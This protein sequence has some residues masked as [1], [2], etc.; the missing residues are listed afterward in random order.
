V[1]WHSHD[2]LTWSSVDLDLPP[3]NH[4]SQ[5][6]EPVATAE[7]F[8]IISRSIGHAWLS[9]NG[10][11]WRLIRTQRVDLNDDSVFH[12]Y[13]GLAVASDD[14]IVALGSK[15]DGPEAGFIDVWVGRFSEML[16]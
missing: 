8:V 7:G 4:G 15:Q 3:G 11:D 12:D 16:R 9:T 13:I 14:L 2:G 10:T 1:A 6:G 5:A